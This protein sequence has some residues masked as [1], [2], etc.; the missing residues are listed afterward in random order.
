MGH[1][2]ENWPA[3]LTRKLVAIIFLRRGNTMITDRSVTRNVT[4]Y[5]AGGSPQ[6]A[7]RL[8]GLVLAVM[9]PLHLAAGDRFPAT[10]RSGAGTSTATATDTYPPPATDYSLAKN[11]V[12]LP[13]ASQAVDVFFLHPTTYGSPDP[14]GSTW[15]SG[16]NQSLAKAYS[17]P[18]IKFHVTTKASVF[19]KAGTNL[20]APFYQQASGTDALAALLYNTAPQNVAAANAAMEVAYTDVANAF[21][22][23]LKYF[24]PVDSEGNRRP[25]ILAGHSQG[26]NQLLWLLERKFSTQEYRRWLVAAYVVGWSVTSDDFSSYPES[27]GNLGI[28][29]IPLTR[30]TGCIITYNTQQSPG[31]WTQTGV[32]LVKK[33]AYSV[34]PISWVATGPNDTGPYAPAS[35]N[36]GAYF[37]QHQLLTYP[38]VEFAPDYAGNQTFEIRN[39]TGAQSINGA[40][41]VNAYNLP[42]PAAYFDLISPYNTLPGWYHHYDYTF[43]YRNIQQDVIDRIEIYFALQ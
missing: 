23:Y 9:V 33:N 32:G 26:S 20:Y 31:D 27:L 15:T 13:N 18:A 10:A 38:P 28:C 34:N 22:Y 21:E 43:F 7:V 19:A 30:Q 6:S 37:Y 16:W 41:V 8:L 12:T 36:A 2:E 25:Y 24:N 4:Q 14:L 40:L 39:Y 42:Y 11:W 5:D 1:R 35:T 29:G 17:D 3:D